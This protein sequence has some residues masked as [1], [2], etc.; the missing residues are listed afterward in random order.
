MSYL[1]CQHR[2]ALRKNDCV[3]S[4]NQC[5][6]T[7]YGDKYKITYFKKPL[8]NKGFEKIKSHNIEEIEFK[9]K[10]LHD[11]DFELWLQMNLHKLHEVEW[12]DIAEDKKYKSDNNIRRAKNV[13]FELAMCN[14][15]EYFCTFTIDEQKYDRE[16]LKNYYKDFSK[17]INN[18]KTKKGY[19]IRYILIPELHSDKKSWHMH[20]LMSGI[21]KDE[22]SLF[23]KGSPIKLIEK[24]Y[25]NWERYQN[26][27]GFCS[28]DKVKSHEKVSN[29]IT[30][31][32]TKDMLNC[33]S[34]VG[35]H[36]YYAT[37]GL[38]R[39]EVI[40]RQEL[41]LYSYEKFD[42]DNEYV[43]VKWLNENE[44]GE[45]IPNMVD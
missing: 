6:I 11:S 15:W 4:E 9:D 5:I 26:K 12:E 13:I 43:A 2:N 20:G 10:Q 16:N 35:C 37:K 42:F 18:L 30:K 27:F 3:Y 31:Y 19:N 28:F 44:L 40:C 21:P 38:K 25:K 29:Y 14:E 17:W 8:R 33:V 7:K 22:L 34:E 1:P 45:W 41:L 23:K 32:I 24:G 39:R 36:M